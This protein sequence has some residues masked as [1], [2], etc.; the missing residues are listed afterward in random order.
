MPQ[1]IQEIIQHQ[2]LSALVFEDEL[3][4]PKTQADWSNVLLKK[5]SFPKESMMQQVVRDA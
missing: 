3:A 5:Q 1:F 4:G 2:S